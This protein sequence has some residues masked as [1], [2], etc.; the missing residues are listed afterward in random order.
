MF[1]RRN[2]L[3]IILAAS[4]F[5]CLVT[6][7]ASAADYP[8]KPITLVAVSA[9]GGSTDVLGRIFASVAEKYMG[10]PFVVVNKTGAAQMV[11]TQEVAKAKPDGYTL[12]LDATAITSII[13]WEIAN[14]RKP[15]ANLDDFILIGSWAKSPTIVLVPQ[16]SAWNTFADLVKDLKAKPG[17][18]AYG[19]SGLYGP[20]HVPVELF[21]NTIGTKARHVPFQGGGP[22]LTA[23]TG[24]HVDF[25]CQFPSSS[26]PL[27]RGNKLK[28]LAVQGN[29]RLKVLPDVP[30]S[31]ELGVDVEYYL[32]NGMSAPKGTPPEVIQK[33]RDVIKKTVV[34]KTF[35]ELVE[36]AGDEVRPMIGDELVKQREKEA[37]VFTKIFQQ[38]LKEKQ[39]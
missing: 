26:I 33:L 29:Q 14:G 34:D 31:K 5:F 3:G 21:L 10:Q 9:P 28:A 25:A 23:L 18:Y 39:Q 7:F 8:V 35:I 11:G 30:T 2:V 22:A 17:Q 4:V 24:G 38:F 6:G 37:A 12:L 20:T 36:K 32:W 19:S 13:G 27:V 15:P 16:N 1:M